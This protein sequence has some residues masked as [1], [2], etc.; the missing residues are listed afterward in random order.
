M[1]ASAMRFYEDLVSGIQDGEKYQ[2]I[3]YDWSDIPEPGSVLNAVSTQ[4]G[5]VFARIEIESVEILS[6]EEC[7][8]RELDGHKNYSTKKELLNDMSTYYSEIQEDDDVILFQFSVEK[9]LR[10]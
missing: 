10:E 7:V 8:N 3:R 9:W 6:I 4:E 5:D 1:V 2:S